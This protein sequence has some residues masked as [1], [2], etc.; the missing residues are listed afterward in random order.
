MK[1]SA[2]LNWTLL[3]ISVLAEAYPKG[4]S[5]S[6][7]V[8][9]GRVQILYFLLG[10]VSAPL[11]GQALLRIQIMSISPERL[12][13]MARLWCMASSYLTCPL[14]LSSSLVL[15]SSLSSWAL[16]LL[17]ASQSFL[18]DFKAFSYPV[19]PS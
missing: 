10:G 6:H 14:D 16:F 19:P 13:T 11:S 17:K 5:Q 9:S 12:R 4:M 7:W 2:N 8:E 15:A 1:M 3:L 18:G